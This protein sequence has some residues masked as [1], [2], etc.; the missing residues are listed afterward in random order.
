MRVC[1][2]VYVSAAGEARTGVDAGRGAGGG[3]RRCGCARA[4]VDADMGARR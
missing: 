2:C 4:G 3:A 1:G